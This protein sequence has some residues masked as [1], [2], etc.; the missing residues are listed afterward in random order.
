MN[1]RSQTVP[2]G[3]A[4]PLAQPLFR[5]ISL[6]GNGVKIGLVAGSFPDGSR[7][8]KLRRGHKLTLL[9]VTDGSRYVIM[10]VRMTRAELDLAAGAGTG[11]AAAKAA[12]AANP[13]A[14][15]SGR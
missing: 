9:D 6:G 11:P 14:T 10:F 3:A 13:A 15:T 8:L 5:L 1:G 2:T 7:T 4:F 12:P